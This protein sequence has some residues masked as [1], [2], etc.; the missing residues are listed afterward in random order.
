[1]P[2]MNHSFRDR[3]LEL[4]P[5]TPA[6]KDHYE[7]EIQ[8]MFNKLTGVR[9]WSFLIAGILSGGLVVVFTA[10]AMLTPADFP[11]YARICFVVGALFS[12][13]WAV[14]GFRVFKRGAKPQDRNHSVLRHGVGLLVIMLTLLNVRDERYRRTTDDSLRDCVLDHGCGMSSTRRGGAIGA[15]DT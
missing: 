9:R 3:L 12:A 6:L 4:E 7:K 11:V 2:E 13:A 1:M 14:L 15:S 8:A 5:V 10:A